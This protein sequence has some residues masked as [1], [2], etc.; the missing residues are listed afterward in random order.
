MF[1]DS[2]LRCEI[3]GDVVVIGG[4]EQRLEAS[5]EAAPIETGLAGECAAV[6]LLE[7]GG[8]NPALG[9]LAVDVA[10]TWLA[11]S[12]GGGDNSGAL[13]IWGGLNAMTSVPAAL[14]V[15][16]LSPGERIDNVPPKHRIP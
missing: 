4:G 2:V 15:G 3:A 16:L 1:G 5:G 8:E 10:V 12:R 7:Q 14:K 6:R 13:R 11:F 9:C